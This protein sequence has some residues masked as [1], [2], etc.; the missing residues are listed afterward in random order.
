MNFKRLVILGLAL[1]VFLLVGCDSEPLSNK[2][3]Q[4]NVNEDL[5]SLGLTKTSPYLYQKPGAKVGF[6][7]NYKG[8]SE[9]GEI[10]NID[11]VFTDGY[12]SGQLQIKL[13]SDTALSL[14]PSMMDYI[15]SLEG[16]SSNKINLSI[17]T[18]NEGKHFLNIFAR[19]T[20]ENGYSSG[21]VFA[22][23]FYVGENAKRK[24]GPRDLEAESV[25]RLP[26]IVTSEPAD[27]P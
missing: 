23:A 12:S 8:F 18:H 20:D 4:T 1:Y 24:I 25:I 21:R 5:T 6:S 26:S 7:H 16:Y 9:V 14:E 10:E 2:T 19:I 11:L 17:Q 13:E 3:A 27:S 22:I 15:F